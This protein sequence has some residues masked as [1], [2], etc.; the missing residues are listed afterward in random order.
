M[1]SGISMQ[2]LRNHDCQL[3]CQTASPCCPGQYVILYPRQTAID[4]ILSIPIRALRQL[5]SVM[6][7]AVIIYRWIEG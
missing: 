4:A 2:L 7:V 6:C 1:A 5:E 3:S